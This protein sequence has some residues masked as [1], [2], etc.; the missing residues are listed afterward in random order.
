[1]LYEGDGGGGWGCE[2]RVVWD[3]DEG[4][5]EGGGNR[6]TGAHGDDKSAGVCAE[7]SEIW[8]SG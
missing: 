2:S 1:M 5:E 6:E 7:L 3:K 8:C 4:V